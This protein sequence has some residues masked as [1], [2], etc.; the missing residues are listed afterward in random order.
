MCQLLLCNGL[1]RKSV[2]FTIGRNVLNFDISVGGP[3]GMYG[4]QERCMRGFGG[5]TGHRRPRNRWEDDIKMHIQ[6][7]G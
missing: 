2:G 7:I 4:G 1:K 3:Y 6:E 5:E